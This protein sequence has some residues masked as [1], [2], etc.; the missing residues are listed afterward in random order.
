VRLDVVLLD[1]SLRQQLVST[2]SLGRAGYAIAALDW[3]PPSMTPAMAS[4]WCTTRHHVADVAHDPRR[5][6]DDVLDFLRRHSCDV[7][8]PAHDGSIAAARQRRAELEH[9]VHVALAPEAALRIAVDKSLT[10]ALAERIGVA[11]PRSRYVTGPAQVPEALEIVGL[12]A[13]VKPVESWV[14]RGS[15]RVRL[16]CREVVRAQEAVAVVER[17]SAAGGR[18]VLQEWAPGRREAVSFLY[19]DGSFRAEF[20]QVAHRMDPPIGGSSV[21][22]ESVP[23]PPD[24]GC[25]GRELVRAM[26]LDGYSEVEFRRDRAGRPLLMEV[27]PRLSASVEIAVRAGVDF[28]R[29]IHTWARGDVVEEIQGYATGRRMR[30]LGG[31][32]HWLLSSLIT[33]G[34]PDTPTRARAVARFGLDFLR[35]SSYDYLDAHD[36][37]PAWVAG[38]SSVRDFMAQ[39]PAG[40]FRRAARLRRQ[41]G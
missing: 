28:P 27:N 2:R 41:V 6:I 11:V 21:L 8:I 19:Q 18:A 16:R 23:V 33:P 25:A 15:A 34:R 29:L 13:V 24:L 22:R 20:A 38:R 4:R 14:D 5:F 30:W 35:R 3:L 9:E 32:I 39:G 12:P 26:G 17:I 10:L 36:L 37:R 7:L 1:A 40:S 31:D